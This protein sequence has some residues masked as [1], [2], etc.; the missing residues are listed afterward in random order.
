MGYT[1][2]LKKLNNNISGGMSFFTSDYRI[3]HI[4]PMVWYYE[5]LEKNERF[6]KNRGTSRV[7]FGYNIGR[8]REVSLAAI[9]YFELCHKST[10]QMG[11]FWDITIVEGYEF[12]RI[13]R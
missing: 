3:A 1:P 13:I 11:V 12:S 5:L 7:N 2:P 10:A 8:K 9:K 6:C 4:E